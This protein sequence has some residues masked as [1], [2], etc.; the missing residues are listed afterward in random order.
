MKFKEHQHV[1]TQSKEVTKDIK[2]NDLIL[3]KKEQR[4][5]KLEPIWEGPYEVKELKYPNLVI[6]R[7][8]KRKREKVHMNQIKMFH[9]SQEN[10]DEVTSSL[11]FE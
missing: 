1:K 8:G 2:L 3:V 11:D 10:Q 4:K 5:H 9:C 6:H 7:V